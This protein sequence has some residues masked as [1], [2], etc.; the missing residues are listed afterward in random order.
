MPGFPSF[1]RSGRELDAR[2]AVSGRFPRWLRGALLRNGPGAF[3]AGRWEARHLFDGLALIQRFDIADGAVAY[4]SRFLRSPLRERVRSGGWAR[5][6]QFG[7]A[8]L[9]TPID[10]AR[11]ILAPEYPGNA[12]VSL[13]EADGRL[14][15]LTETPFGTELDADSLATRGEHAF[16]DERDE[17]F[18]Q[19]TTAHH[20]RDPVNGELVNVVTKFAGRERYYRCWRLREDSAKREAFATLPVDYPA[21]LH[22]F[23]LTQRHLALVEGPLVLNPLRL[24]LG[25]DSYIGAYRWRPERGT[26]LRVVERASGRVVANATLSACF[27]FHHLNAYDE[28]DEVVMDLEVYPD[29]DVIAAF[30]LDQAARGARRPASHLQRWRIDLR[31]GAIATTQLLPDALEFGTVAANRAT[32]PY[33]YAYGVGSGD[34]SESDAY[35][36]LLKLDLQRR[37]AATWRLEGHRC[38][39]PLFVP[40]PGA[41]AEDEGVVLAPVHAPEGERDFLLALDATSWRELGRAWL[42]EH[43]PY[44]FHGCFLPG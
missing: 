3:A 14:L 4:R 8:P 1:F 40:A 42:P 28:G 29:P 2:L 10:I 39:E 23:A 17:L 41:V 43:A 18:A 31:T 26:R 19:T 38:A 37:T 32:L 21:Y 16:G 9:R 25:E 33:R 11:M 27:C 34:E 24:L 20:V 5:W 44:S 12:A 13:V 15:A 35:E 7:G 30:Y 22:S 6:R 36:R